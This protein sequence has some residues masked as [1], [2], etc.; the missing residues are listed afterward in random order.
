MNTTAEQARNTHPMVVIAAIAVTLFAITGIG[1]MLGWLPASNGNPQGSNTPALSAESTGSSGQQGNTALATGLSAPELPAGKPAA[2]PQRPV[3]AAKVQHASRPVPERHAARA[4]Q[5]ARITAHDPVRSAETGTPVRSEPVQV[6]AAQ[7][8]APP[9]AETQLPAPRALCQDCGTIESVRQVEHKA[10]GSGAGAAAGG[11]LGGILGHQMG[12]GR[13]RDIMTV[14]GAVGGAVAGH[15]VE[16]NVRKTMSYEVVVRF[17][18]GTSRT[19]QQ[20]NLPPWHI[21]DRVRVVNSEI[22]PNG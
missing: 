18:D 5:G 7:P 19:L 12:N 10:E 13:G 20:P 16:K 11:V 4:D 1:A 22:Q 2:E 3:A 8:P 17:E 9:A 14:L 21:G 15:Q 6:A